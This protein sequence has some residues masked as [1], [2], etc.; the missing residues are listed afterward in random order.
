GAVIW[1]KGE[2]TIT[3]GNFTNNKVRGN[4]GVLYASEFSTFTLAGGIFQGNGAKRGG[5]VHTVVGTA[6]YVEGGVYY[7]GNVAESQGGVF[8]VADGTQLK[9]TGGNF[10]NNKADFGGFLYKEGAGETS[11]TG[12]SIVGH[13]AVD[14]GAIYAV[15]GATVHWACDIRDTSAISG[16]AM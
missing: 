12:A 2:L 13:D 10:T 5:V 11:C 1:S 14:G 9:I 16:P 4:G 15:D 3:D 6:L 7:S 8:L